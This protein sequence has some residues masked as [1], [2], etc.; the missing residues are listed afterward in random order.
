MTMTSKFVNMTSSSNVFDGVLFILSGLVIG[1]S[2]MSISSLVLEL[3]QFSF[4][5]DWPEIWKSG[6]PPSEFWP[7]YQHWG[8][9]RIPKLARMP[10]IKSCRML[11]NAKV[12]A[13]IVYEL[14]KLQCAVSLDWS[15]F[16]SSWIKSVIVLQLQVFEIFRILPIQC[17]SCSKQRLNRYMSYFCKI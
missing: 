17:S 9:S 4:I 1:P 6:I 3:W 8:K 14:L 11:Q 5:R 15:A 2:L 7:K 10:L 13:F 16:K 12:T